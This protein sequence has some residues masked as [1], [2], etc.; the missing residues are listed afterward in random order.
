[1]FPALMKHRNVARS[2]DNI[3]KEP[4]KASGACISGWS[5][6]LWVS[7][8]LLKCPSSPPWPSVAWLSAGKQQLKG[9][10]S[11]CL[12]QG[13]LGGVFHQPLWTRDTSTQIR[14]TDRVLCG[15][16]LM[17]AWDWDT[18]VTLFRDDAECRDGEAEFVI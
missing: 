15:I 17:R 4:S 16:S 1:M 6:F 5:F 10:D 18:S 7:F 2:Q 9:S 14:V 13:G 11:E 3:K 12:A 8:L